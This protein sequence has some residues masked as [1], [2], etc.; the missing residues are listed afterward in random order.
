WERNAD[1]VAASVE[2]LL[3][4]R[5][6]DM[7]MLSGDV[8]AVGLLRDALSRETRDRLIEVQGGSRG[9]ALDRGPFRE[10]LDAATSSFIAARQRELA[11]RFRERQARDGASV[12]GAAEVGQALARGQVEELVFVSGREPAGIEELLRTALS[13]DAGVSAREEDTLGIPEGAGARLRWRDGSTA[14]HGSGSTSG[15]SRRAS[16]PAGTSSQRPVGP[17]PGPVPA[18]RPFGGRPRPR[19]RSG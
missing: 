9:I 11:E 4:E 7:V 12:G 17:A 15:D 10:E 6:V 14:S 19:R 16:A 2:K 13:T 5:S 1:A 8:R 18:R 3:R